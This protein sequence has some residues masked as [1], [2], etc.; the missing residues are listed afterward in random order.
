M[1]GSIKTVT[2]KEARDNF[3]DILG[4]VYYG[5]QP[6]VIEKKGRPF[7]VVISPEEYENYKKV[8]KK[9]FF[10]IVNKIQA[11]NKGVDPD[12]VLKDV[13]EVVE[14]VRQERYEKQK[15][16]SSGN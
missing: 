15:Q 2:A 5:K 6:V 7:A 14:E 4:M 11:K 1:N 8:A 3:T 10:E 12:K 16:A 9:R 13:T